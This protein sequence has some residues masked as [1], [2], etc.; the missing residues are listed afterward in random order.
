MSIHTENSKRINHHG[1]VYTV[2]KRKWHSVKYL[3]NRKYALCIHL[4]ISSL[5]YHH[6]ELYKPLS[7]MKT[8]PK[9]IGI[10]ESMLQINKQPVNN[11]SLAN[12]VHEHTPTESGNGPTH[13]YID[14]IL[15]YKVRGDLKI[16]E[17]NFIEIINTKQKNM[18]I[19]SIYKHA[20]QGTHDFNENCIL[21]V[22]DKLSREKKGILIM[23]GFHSIMIW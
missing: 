2:L 9:I 14:Q 10:S 13:L 23:G 8:K 19:G 5:S 18:I 15:K 1:I 22:M 17:S 11:I 7:S 3:V 6:Q 12:D 16:H 20:K 4:N 21:P